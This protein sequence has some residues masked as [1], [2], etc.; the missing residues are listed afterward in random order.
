MQVY[1]FPLERKNVGK[2]ETY[3]G[4]THTKMGGGNPLTT[5]QKTLKGQILRT[6]YEPL[7][8]RRGGGGYPDLSGPTT[9]KS[10]SMFISLS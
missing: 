2:T 10:V 8:T 9:K 3:L 5:K 7:W 4:K 1:S 6:K